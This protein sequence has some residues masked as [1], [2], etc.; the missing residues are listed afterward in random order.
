MTSLESFPGLSDRQ[1]SNIKRDI[2]CQCTAYIIILYLVLPLYSGYHQKCHAPRIEEEIKDP[3]VEWQC[4]ICVFD[5]VAKVH[6]QVMLIGIEQTHLCQIVSS[7]SEEK[8]SF[9]S[10]TEAIYF[11]RLDL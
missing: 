6:N 2:H 11:V 8:I 3:D 5:A 10:K 7:F 9:L 1:I 4:R